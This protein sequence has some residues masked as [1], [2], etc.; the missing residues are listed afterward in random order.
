MP[1]YE[2]KCLACEERFEVLQRMGE[3]NENLIC[4]TCGASKPVKQFSAFAMSSQ[5]SG[6]S[7]SA[8]SCSTTSR[9]S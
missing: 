1:I 2:Y 3:G 6:F 7:S 8:N 4:P 9:F 5:G